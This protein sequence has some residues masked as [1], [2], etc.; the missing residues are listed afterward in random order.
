MGLRLAIFH[1]R[2]IFNFEVKINT[3]MEQ[4]FEAIQYQ[5]AIYFNK[6]VEIVVEMKR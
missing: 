1:C 6:I 3:T 5:T 4:Y 2:S